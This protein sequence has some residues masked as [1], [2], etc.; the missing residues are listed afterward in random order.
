MGFRSIRRKQGDEYF[1]NNDIGQKSLAK[2]F[3]KIQ[4]EKKQKAPLKKPMQVE[5]N[6]NDQRGQ[7]TFTE[8]AVK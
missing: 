2:V 1:Y 3:K 6:T 8:M 4:T 7:M 5:K